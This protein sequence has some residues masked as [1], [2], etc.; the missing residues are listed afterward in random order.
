M[1]YKPLYS[2]LLLILVFFTFI[3]GV[4]P[5]AAGDTN[6]KDQNIDPLLAKVYKQENVSKWWV[7][8]KLDGVRAIWNGKKLHFR[9]GKLISAPDWFIE[10][11]PEQLMD[12]ELW[13][14]R[15]TFEKL[16]GIV[17]KIQPN[18]N[19]WRQV[20]YM[21]FELPEHPGTFTRRVRKMVKLTETLKI[22]WLQPI[23]QIRL[24]SENALLNMLDEIVT[25]GGEGLM[26]HQADSLYH[27][28]RS[29]DLLK[30]KPW[31]DAEATVVEILPGKGKFNGMMGSLLVADESGRIFRIGTGF[32]NKERRNPPTV[33][34]LITYKFT[35]TTKKGLPKFASF[36]RIY[37]QF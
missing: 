36:L 14:G 8:E 16:S 30:L 34:T 5:L 10:N 7:S 28:G 24:N 1:F 32:S 6:D 21:L 17:R 19:E 31:Q 15:G 9:S 25:K 11:F 12:G 22:S 26:L 35:G 37:Q 33:G 18:H 2:Q 23:P 27:S 20:S 13:M 29:N 3:I 4:F